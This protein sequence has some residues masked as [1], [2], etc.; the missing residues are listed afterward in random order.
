MATDD[1]LLRQI[2][3]GD[4]EAFSTVYRAH[5]DAVFRF[6]LHMSGNRHL[7]EEVTQEV[8]LLLMRQPK[9]FDPKRGTL[10]AYLYGIARNFVR[11]HLDRNRAWDSL[12]EA[13][14]V[15]ASQNDLLGDLTR[16]ETIDNVRQAVLQ[17]PGNYR[18]VVVLCEFQELSYE[19][20]AKVLGCAV[21]TV[22]SRLHRARAL[23]LGK[24]QARC[25][26]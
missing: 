21:G 25:L 19:E 7:A 2:A 17:L 8:F 9:A 10:S 12:D 3:A 15:A 5:R 13:R 20:A 18:E 6:A 22:R 16:L 24:L 26:V 11:R 1:K 14:D 4:A 23:L